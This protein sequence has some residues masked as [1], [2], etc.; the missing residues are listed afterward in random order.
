MSAF[1]PVVKRGLKDNRVKIKPWE[2][3]RPFPDP[4]LRIGSKDADSKCLKDGADDKLHF[5][6]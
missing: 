2:G 4:S 5:M 1:L 6:G 3:S